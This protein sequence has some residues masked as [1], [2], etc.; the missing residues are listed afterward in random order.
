MPFL[1]A[2]H[3]RDSPYVVSQAIQ[4]TY[5]CFHV[6]KSTKSLAFDLKKV[7]LIST[8]IISQRV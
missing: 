6:R 7:N 2:L 5:F 4:S 3:F 8:I 1:D